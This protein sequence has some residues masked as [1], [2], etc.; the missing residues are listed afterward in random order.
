[1]GTKAICEWCK[2]PFVKKYPGD[3]YHKA[4]KAA[5]KKA[6][7]EKIKAER[8]KKLHSEKHYCEQCGDEFLPFSTRARLC[9]KCRDNSSYRKKPK[10]QNYTGTDEKYLVRGNISKDRV[11]LGGC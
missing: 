8:L 11:G 4:C 2:K 1:M 5:M 9:T 7:A 3:K 6:K 10:V